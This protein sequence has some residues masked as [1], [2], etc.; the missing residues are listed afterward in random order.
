MSTTPTLLRTARNPLAEALQF[1]RASKSLASMLPSLVV[2]GVGSLLAT[3][4]VLSVGADQN[5]FGRWME[6]WLTAWPV[7]FPIAYLIARISSAA[8]KAAAS[9]PAGMALMDIEAA[10]AGATAKNGLKV[11]R[12]RIRTFEVA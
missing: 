5:F 2:T 11:R 3:G 1:V 7:A 4:L 8:A 10:S 9:K 6:T 12:K